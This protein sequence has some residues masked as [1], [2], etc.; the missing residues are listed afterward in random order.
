MNIASL[1]KSMYG[2]FINDEI[3]LRLLYYTPKNQIDNPLDE[4]KQD[5]LNL[6]PN[7]KFNVINNL[8]YF[9]DK[10]LFLD[11]R[12]KFNR[13]NFYLGQRTP[14]RVYSSGARQLINNP[15]VSRQE[16]IIDIHVNV[17]TDRIDFRM[18]DIIDRINKIM[19]HKDVKQFTTL[20]FDYGYNIEQT[21][22]GFVG[23]RMIYYVK[24]NQEGGCI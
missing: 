21:P 20:K 22:D 1:M 10:K 14:D 9:T 24:A 13:V 7:E 4:N 8:I 23:Y 6:P 2:I 19:L 15:L 3:L 17:E 16:V 12:N 5:L 11:P 18:W